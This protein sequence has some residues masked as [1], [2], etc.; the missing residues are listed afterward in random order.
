MARRETQLSAGLAAEGSSRHRDSAGR[1]SPESGLG[2]GVGDVETDCDAKM[3][4]HKR[5]VPYLAPQ[6]RE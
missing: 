3:N 6:F 4:T 2:F 1:A 5:K